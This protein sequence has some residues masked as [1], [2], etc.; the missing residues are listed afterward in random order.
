MHLK[1]NGTSIPTYGK[2][3]VDL[4]LDECGEEL[5][6]G[7]V[8][9]IH[10]GR[11]KLHGRPEGAGLYIV[12]DE[13]IEIFE[14]HGNP[15]IFIEAHNGNPADCMATVVTHWPAEYLPPG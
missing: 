6:E 11:L 5:P 3:E 15:A 4:Y 8:I 9:R 7:A 2:F 14:R 13:S 1:V 12:A 10:G